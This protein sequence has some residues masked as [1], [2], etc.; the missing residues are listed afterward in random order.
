MLDGLKEALQ[1]VVGLGNDSEKIQVLEICGKTYA[2][3]RL[4]R[5]GSPDRAEAVHVSTLSAIIDY[6]RHCSSEFP[7]DQKMILQIQAPNRVRLMTSL[8]VERKRE[9]LMEAVAETS[10]F[11]FDFWYDQERF[12]IEMQANF[13]PSP[14]RELVLRFAGNVEQKNNQTFSDDGITQVATMSVG[15]ASKSDVIV[16][17]P[18]ELVPYRT[19]QEVEQPYSKFVFRLQDNHG[20]KFSLIEAEGGIWKSEAVRN[21][22]EYFE[23]HLS[24]PDLADRIVVI[25]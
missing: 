5:Y 12:M 2:N 21:I 9:V 16:P 11:Q 24:D 4:E 18:V 17:N 6:I 22:R 25:G 3:R 20:P 10:E 15:A 14:D 23:S 7:M 19:F 13:Q 8:N 1:Y